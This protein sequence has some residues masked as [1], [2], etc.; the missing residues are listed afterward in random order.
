MG[1]RAACRGTYC[2]T[3]LSL[4][5]L[6]SHS[7]FFLPPHNF[8]DMRRQ[9]KSLLVCV[10]IKKRRTNPSVC[11][12]SKTPPMPFC[13]YWEL[14]GLFSPP[15]NPLGTS[16][17]PGEVT[18]THCPSWKSCTGDKP[19]F[20]SSKEKV[21][22]LGSLVPSASLCWL[23]GAFLGSSKLGVCRLGCAA[24]LGPPSLQVCG[25]C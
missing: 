4:L 15:P 16:P 17:W 14:R 22:K 10:L 6:P 25:Q 21:D 9:L 13:C 19:D 1:R 18:Q 5:F 11:A 24:A 8:C 20:Y 7:N 2:R 12:R 3:A 23:H